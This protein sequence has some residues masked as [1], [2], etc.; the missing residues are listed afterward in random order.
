MSDYRIRDSDGIMLPG[1]FGYG[2]SKLLAVIHAKELTRRLE[3]NQIKGK[4][5][6]CKTDHTRACLTCLELNQHEIMKL[7]G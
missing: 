5:F 1:W 2:T 3:G 7:F 6:S 4:R